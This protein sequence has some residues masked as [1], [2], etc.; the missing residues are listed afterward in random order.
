MKMIAATLLAL[1]LA[2]TPVVAQQDELSPELRAIVN[3]SKRLCTERG[4]KP[5]S[6]QWESCV[7]AD[8]GQRWARLQIQRI[9]P[10]AVAPQP[11]PSAPRII[12]PPANSGNVYV[13]EAP[14][15]CIVSGN[16]VTCQ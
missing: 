16:V 12:V 8:G 3:F 11:T 10:V 6:A 5:D 15:T 4:F 9:G 1:S 2:S 7:M 13:R 14:R